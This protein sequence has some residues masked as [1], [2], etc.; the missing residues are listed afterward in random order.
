MYEF[1]GCFFHGCTTCFKHRT[2]RHLKLNNA[3]AHEVR[4]RT[5]L[6]TQALREAGYEVLEMWECEWSQ[7]KKDNT[8]VKT[9]VEQLELVSPLN[10]WDAFYGGR[11][12]AIQLLRD[13][14]DHET[15]QYDDFTSL[16][17]FVNKNC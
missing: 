14:K 15:I 11:T 17:P 10:P 6:K 12:E 5:E 9:F 2:Q 16:Y 4:E 7:L 1:H 3:N 13:V 8:K